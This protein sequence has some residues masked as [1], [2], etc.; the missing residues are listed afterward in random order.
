MPSIF[1]ARLCGALEDI[2][3]S[4]KLN[5]ETGSI[6][7]ATS[8]DVSVRKK[9]SKPKNKE[10]IK[11]NEEK[12]KQNEETYICNKP[13]GSLNALGVDIQKKIEEIS[14]FMI[15][16]VPFSNL[17]ASAASKFKKLYDG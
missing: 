6:C 11:I 3:V 1:L 15:E 8:A 16:Y 17:L 12:G 9:K 13:S 5:T 2:I 7:G 10:I 4:S 14:F